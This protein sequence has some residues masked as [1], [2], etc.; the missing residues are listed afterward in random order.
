MEETEHSAG[1]RMSRACS[2]ETFTLIDHISGIISLSRTH[3]T[4]NDF[5]IAAAA[6]L[7]AVEERLGLSKSE[8]FIFACFLN[9]FGSESA[10]LSDL[11]KSLKWENIDLYRRMKDIE[12]LGK[13]KFIR[14][15]KGRSRRSGGQREAAVYYVPAEVIEAVTR[16]EPLN[17]SGYDNLSAEGIFS[18]LEALFGQLES[19]DTDYEN[20]LFEAN[21]LISANSHVDFAGKLLAL[22]LSE[23]D[24]VLLLYIIHRLVNRDE[25]FLTYS[26]IPHVFTPCIASRIIR[27]LKNGTNSLI[28][29]GF[30]ENKNEGGFGNPDMWV[31]SD[32]TLNTLLAGLELPDKQIKKRKDVTPAD[33]IAEKRLYFN[34]PEKEK[35]EKLVSLLSPEKFDLVEE[36]LKQNGLRQG[37]ACLFYG[38]PG[39]GKTETALQLAKVTGRDIMKVNVADTKSKWFGDSEKLVKNLFARYRALAEE[40]RKEK[41][42]VPILLFNEADAIIGRRKEFSGPRNGPDQTEN[43]IQNILLEEIENLRGIIIATTNLTK[44]MDAAFERRFLYKIEFGLPEKQTREEI[45][46]SQIPRLAEHDAALLAGRFRFSGGQI[47]NISRKYVVDLVLD[48]L[49]PSLERLVQYCKDEELDRETPPIGFSA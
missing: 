21:D 32:K 45:W 36:G 23:Q 6:H 13:K 30:I 37:F 28:E 22:E 7:D 44:N 31:L 26:G 33:G 16:D 8:A 49:D 18:A 46:K 5:F 29:Q 11:A 41:A 34:K 48:G 27:T 2:Q 43:A 25:S 3:G 19:R 38:P 1:T 20:F 35:I 4:G 9:E 47:E 15:I 40:Y 12:S 42:P 10:T 24:F 39:T 14:R 17:P